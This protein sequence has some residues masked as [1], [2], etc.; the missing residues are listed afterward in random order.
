MIAARRVTERQPRGRLACGVEAVVVA[1]V[2]HAE[3]CVR[4]P[5]AIEGESDGVGRRRRGHSGRR[6]NG[7][8]ARAGSAPVEV[9]G[10]RTG[11]KRGKK[12]AARSK[13]RQDRAR[14]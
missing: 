11:G 14:A 8:N 2:E 3:E 7:K 1:V 12:Y 13:R 4:V 10:A 6:R 5:R 9:E